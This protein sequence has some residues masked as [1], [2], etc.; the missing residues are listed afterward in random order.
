M[1]LTI[2]AFLV[3]VSA[4]AQ[5]VSLGFKVGAPINDPGKNLITTVNQGRWTGGP[6]VE[7][8]LFHGLS[9]EANALYRNQ[10]REEG[11]PLTFNPAGN[12]FLF[13]STEQTRKWDVPLLL[14]YRVPVK[15]DKVTPFVSA[16][17][18]FTHEST[19]RLTNFTCLGPQGS[20]AP[21]EG[22]YPPAALFSESSQLRAGPTIGAGFEI[23]VGRMKIVP[24]VRFSHLRN[25][26]TN[27][28][29]AVV[30]F[31]WGR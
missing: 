23:P 10:R 11:F 24:E 3:A 27:Q 6:S 14:K 29:T 16:G 7:L 15:F 28:V 9:I 8:H 19:G 25:P 31:R 4:S 1:R 2:F 21:I 5:P 18:T 30:G 17:V 22:G 12:S 13:R 20:C 26:N